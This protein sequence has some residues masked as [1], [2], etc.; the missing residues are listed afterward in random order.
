[1][2]EVLDRRILQ[3]LPPGLVC[4]AAGR[5]LLAAHARC[6]SLLPPARAAAVVAVG[7]SAPHRGDDGILRVFLAC[8]LC[9]SKSL[10]TTA[11]D[12]CCAVVAGPQGFGWSQTTRVLNRHLA[13]AC[14]PM[15]PVTQGQWLRNLLAMARVCPSPWP[16]LDLLACLADVWAHGIARGKLGTSQDPTHS[17]PLAVLAE[18]LGTVSLAMTED[19]AE[20]LLA[21]LQALISTLATASEA[22]E[23][24]TLLLARYLNAAAVCVARTRPSLARML[25]SI[26]YS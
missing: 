13:T 25:P 21:S 8:E 1:V 17:P 14:A 5:R 9:R 24:P 3:H 15:P 19:A 11:M 22:H 16:A 20:A 2:L 23:A 26:K 12:S 6:I 7:A 10:P 18:N 4:E